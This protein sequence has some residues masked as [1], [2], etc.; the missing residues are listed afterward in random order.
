MGDMVMPS[1]LIIEDDEDSRRAIA[2]LFASVFPPG[3]PADN[4]TNF[5]ESSVSELNVAIT[6]AGKGGIS[7]ARLTVTRTAFLLFVA[8][9][10][11]SRLRCRIA[12]TRPAGAP[13]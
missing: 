10:R 11:W 1:V 2:A 9:S 8:D 4:A 3:V 13:A 5:G 6:S 7:S 12:I